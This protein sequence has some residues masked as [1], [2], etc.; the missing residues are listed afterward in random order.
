MYETEISSGKDSMEP[1]VA[2]ALFEPKLVVFEFEEE[3]N[4][5]YIALGLNSGNFI[6]GSSA[7]MK[8]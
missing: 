2:G 4:D 7:F 3:Y 1:I 5:T 6:K 8:I